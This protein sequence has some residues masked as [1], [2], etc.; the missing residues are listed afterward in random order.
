MFAF[1]DDIMPFTDG[2]VKTTTG[3]RNRMKNKYPCEECTIRKVRCIWI[4]NPKDSDLPLCEACSKRGVSVCQPRVLLKRA[5]RWKVRRGKASDVYPPEPPTP[6]RVKERL[7]FTDDQ[8]TQQTAVNYGQIN[9][10]VAQPG[11]V[12][13]GLGNAPTRFNAVHEVETP[14]F[15][16]HH[17]S[18][19]Y[20]PRTVPDPILQS[21]PM[22]VDVDGSTFQQRYRRQPETFHP[23]GSF[24]E[25]AQ[26]GFTPRLQIF[27]PLLPA[28]QPPILA[29]H[30]ISVSK[31]AIMV[32]RYTQ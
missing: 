13:G 19:S 14:S 17:D 1:S 28:W 10:I 24:V 15:L 26:D 8:H 32:H 23:N 21:L 5:K 30:D 25:G 4:R 29:H 18:G 7:T 22:H 3:T 2:I 16:L 6:S 12:E 20:S 31:D 27:S 9:A 11:I